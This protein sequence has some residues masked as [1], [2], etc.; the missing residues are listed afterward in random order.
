[1]TA[2]ALTCP[3]PAHGAR[4]GVRRPRKMPETVRRMPLLSGGEWLMVGRSGVSGREWATP[5][6]P[7]RTPSECSS[8]RPVAMWTSTTR[9]EHTIDAKGRLVLPAPCVVRSARWNAHLLNNYGALFTHDGW[10]TTSRRLIEESGNLHA[11]EL[12][13][14]WAMASPFVPDAQNRIVLGPILRDKAQLDG[15]VTIVGSVT[16]AAIYDRDAWR[17]ACR[18]SRAG[19]M[20]I[21]WP[22]SS[23]SWVSCDVAASVMSRPTAPGRSSTLHPPV[24]PK[25][26]PSDDARVGHDLRPRPSVPSG[27]TSRRLPCRRGIALRRD[28][29]RCVTPVV[30]EDAARVR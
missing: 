27:E 11:R 23:K 14:L 7:T 26:G 12:Q 19:R 3:F 17:R 18:R 20:A 29:D 2:R 25:C 1:M 13:Y 6:H 24:P 21:R 22:R 16:H 4:T 30:H 28:Q 10:E 5:V 15:E 8:T 9:F